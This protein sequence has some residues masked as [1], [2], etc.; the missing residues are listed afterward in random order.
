M[1]NERNTQMMNKH[2]M[3]RHLSVLKFKDYKCKKCHKIVWEHIYNSK[4]IITNIT[5][6]RAPS[7][8]WLKIRYYNKMGSEINMCNISDD[9]WKLW[10]ILR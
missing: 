8:T 5:V 2:K 1:E 9:E 10:E 3:E 7:R 6:W 4:G